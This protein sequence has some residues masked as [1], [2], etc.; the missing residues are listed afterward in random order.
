V[1]LTGY[2][3]DLEASETTSDL[4]AAMQAAATRM[5]DPF[6]AGEAGSSRA[7]FDALFAGETQDGSEAEPGEDA[8]A[9]TEVDVPEETPSTDPASQVAEDVAAPEEANDDVDS[10]EEVEPV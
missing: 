5:D 9:V 7:A 3:I 1:K 2:K 4:D 10:D 8:E 6:A